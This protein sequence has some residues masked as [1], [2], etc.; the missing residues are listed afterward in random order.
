M[1]KKYIKGTKHSEIEHYD[2]MILGAGPAGLTASI[3]AQRYGL[4]SIVVSKTVG[5]TANLAGELENWPGFMG[6]GI[7]LMNKIKIQ[8]EGFGAKI[9]EDEIKKIEKDD[10]GFVLRL[11]EHEIHGK[12]LIIALGTEHRQLNIP[13]EKEFLGRGVSYCATCDGNFFRGKDVAV[14]GGADSAAKA[15]LY[16]AKI[17]KKVN[18]IYRK[19][20]MRC[21]PISLSNIC[22]TPNIEIFYYSNPVEII[23]DKK[24]KGIKILKEEKEGKKEKIDLNVDGVFIEA[25]ATPAVEVV[26]ELGLEFE[27]NYIVSDKGAR[28]NVKG[29][30]VAGDV[31]N[32]EMKQMVTAAA[33]G[34]I[35]AKSAHEF[36]LK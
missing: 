13:G 3:Y 26:R 33:E 12:T 22:K 8:A 23:G 21:E 14:I 5:G 11:E 31:S 25:G 17:C 27:G 16:L 20:E 34:A 2:V 24:V 28:T 18:I 9:I 7:E 35:A 10:N 32:N 29:V 1:V 36:L 30:F 4:S 15:A 19:H 6:S